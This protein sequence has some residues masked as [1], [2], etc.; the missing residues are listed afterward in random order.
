MEP[1]LNL[2]VDEVRFWEKLNGVR[3]RVCWV[4]LQLIEDPIEDP[5]NLVF[6]IF[7]TLDVNHDRKEIV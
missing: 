6:K 5:H 1:P 2:R 7:D 4:T 3:P